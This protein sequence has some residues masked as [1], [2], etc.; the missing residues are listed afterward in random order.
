MISAIIVTYNGSRWIIKCLRSLLNSTINLKV[1]V[2]DNYSVDNTVSLIEN[3]FPEVKIIKLTAN[4]GFGKANNIG[5]AHAINTG[6]EYFFLINQ[7]VY[8]FADTVKNLYENFV[9]AKSTIGV[10][11]PIHLNGTGNALDNG[12]TNHIYK[13][14]GYDILKMV[15][16]NKV[17]ILINVPFVNAAAWFLS[18]ATFYEVGGFD[19]IFKHYG[20][21]NNYLNRAAAKNIYAAVCL[22]AS[23]CHDREIR[24]PSMHRRSFA[25]KF[26][27]YLI[28]IMNPDNPFTTTMI[29]T[30]FSLLKNALKKCIRFKF[31]EA[32]LYIK[33]LFSLLTIPGKMYRHRMLYN[34]DK[35]Y[36]F[37]DL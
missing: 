34:S 21:D 11:S 25:L 3:N 26:R 30:L 1:I 16:L 36:L 28:Q 9:Q 14:A 6:T 35:K 4:L 19:P 17:P 2:V 10:L 32:I 7:D 27:L 31:G 8:V 24:T 37:I 18:K 15:F 12:F 23:I 33:I 5:I 29:K 13:D 22:K 20:E